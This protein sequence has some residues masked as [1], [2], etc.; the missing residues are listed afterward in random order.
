MK[1]VTDCDIIEF[2]TCLPHCLL[3]WKNDFQ[4][5]DVII[6]YHSFGCVLVHQTIYL[7]ECVQYDRLHYEYAGLSVTMINGNKVSVNVRFE[8]NSETAGLGMYMS[9]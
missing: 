6:V 7:I 4:I 1:P 8:L 3:S 9:V 2:S 5:V